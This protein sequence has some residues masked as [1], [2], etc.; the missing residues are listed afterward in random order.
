MRS[1]YH[2]ISN[3][4]QSK[5]HYIKC[6]LT[7]LTKQRKCIGL[8][9]NYVQLPSDLKAILNIALLRFQKYERKNLFCGS[10]EV[11]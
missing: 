10:M 1:C 9:H 8:I 5:T 11:V 3:L 2:I 6:N 7:L 4:C